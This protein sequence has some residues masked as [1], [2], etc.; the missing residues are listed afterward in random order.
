[1]GRHRWIFNLKLKKKH[2]DTAYSSWVKL[3]EGVEMVLWIAEV[4]YISG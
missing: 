4:K 1:M 3:N 2:S